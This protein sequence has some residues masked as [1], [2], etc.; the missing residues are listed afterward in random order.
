LKNSI[1]EKFTPIDLFFGEL[2]GIT[3][4]NLNVAVLNREGRPLYVNNPDFKVAFE[5]EE[6]KTIFNLKVI[7][8]TYNNSRVIIYPYKFYGRDY[9]LIVAK[10]IGSLKDTLNKIILLFT[11]IMI[12]LFVIFISSSNFAIQR[13]LSAVNKVGNVAQKIEKDNFQY[14]IE[15]KYNTKEIDEM[16]DIF[17][18]MLDR[19]ESSFTRI[20]QFTS[21]V[22][23]ELK[24]PIT[25]IKN[26]IEVE[27]IET[28][29]SEE[30]K[31][32]LIDILEEVNWLVNII[33]DL[34][35]MTRMESGKA[36]LSVENFDIKNMLEDVLELM[37]FFAE[38]N[39]IKLVGDNIESIVYQGDINKLKRVAINLI[40]NG[41]KY[42]KKGGFVEV[43][44]YQDD[45]NVYI[46]IEDNG[47]GIKA[48]NVGK[49]FERFYR[50]NVVR[51]TKK[52]GTGL[53][54]AIAEFVV[55]LHKGKILIESNEGIGTSF[56]VVLPKNSV[57]D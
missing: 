6:L 18:N 11:I 39:E 24:T 4:K 33:N 9:F 41:I 42:N 8:K 1:Q 2:E 40:S 34:L 15:E 16:I 53:G 25:S 17:N 52:S 37:D 55:K 19:M 46:K 51:T 50:E 38:E 13:V 31:E 44:S 35:L 49:I 20:K 45:Y 3:P 32:A 23:H 14:R 30:Y 28:R 26:T 47:I 54:L 7:L 27:L 29:S 48:D 21:D 36:N 56:T 10:E 57:G 43:S 22:S 5:N 12:T